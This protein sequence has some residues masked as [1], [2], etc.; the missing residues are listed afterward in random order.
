MIFNMIQPTEGGGARVGE[1]NMID[2]TE[3]FSARIEMLRMIRSVNYVPVP[4]LL[5]CL[6]Q[7]SGT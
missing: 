3:G 5:I 1:G 2:N 6:H 7:S 4:A